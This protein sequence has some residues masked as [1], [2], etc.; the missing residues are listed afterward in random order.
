MVDAYVLWDEML[1]DAG[2]ESAT[3]PPKDNP[4]NECSS[5]LLVVDVFREF[6]LLANNRV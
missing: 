2:L 6:F 3:P 5:K 4:T 1:G